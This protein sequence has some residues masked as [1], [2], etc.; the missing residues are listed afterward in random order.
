VEKFDLENFPK[1]ESAKKMLSTVS[2]GFYD[3]SYVGKWL[4][5]VMGQEY[6][7]V[8][9]L[10]EDLPNQMFPETAT[11]GLMYHEMKWGLPVR[12]DLDYEERRKLI[13]QRRDYR[14]P[15]TP[16]RMETYL[17][18][19]MDFEF[20]VLDVHDPGE[21]NF[22]LEHPNIFKVIAIGEG[23]LDMKSLREKLDALKQSH[24]LYRVADWISVI[25]DNRN[26]EKVN[27]LR[28]TNR[29]AVNF[30]GLPMLNGAHLLD[31][32][33][34]L[35]GIGRYDLV[36]GLKYD[37]G[38]V[39]NSESAEFDRLVMRTR[40]TNNESASAK[41]AGN[42]AFIMPFWNCTVLDGD[43]NLDG[44]TTLDSTRQDV[45]PTCTIRASIQNSEDVGTATL[46]IKRNLA[47]LDGSLR[48]NGS[49]LLNSIYRKE[50]I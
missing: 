44:N 47:Y 7:T 30:W 27:V 18:N 34:L 28:V 3:T 35:G 43:L 14:A 36:V 1:S 37:Q 6:D 21:Y 49:S 12:N 19:S 10:M 26:L 40:V 45:R 22:A 31:G 2:D 20:H 41:S 33:L 4:F 39:E 11:W 29:M 48:L 15:M 16:Y 32:S 46:T 17:N 42:Y 23:T 38:E 24:T 5:E 13:F 25:L 50:E 9:E 8:N